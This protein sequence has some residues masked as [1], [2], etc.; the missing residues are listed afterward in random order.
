[1]ADAV[2]PIQARRWIVPAIRETRLESIELP[3]PGP[4]E[5]RVRTEASLVSAGTELAIYT[6]IH[7]G[8]TNPEARWPKLPVSMGYMGVVRVE[9]VGEK[10]TGLEP[11]HRLLT[12]T[13]HGSHWLLAVPPSG[14][15]PFWP[16]PSDL[17]ASRLVLARMGKTAITSVCQAGSTVAQSV[18]VVGLGIVG[19]MAL[20]LF[21]AAGAHPAIGVDP[22]GFRRGLALSGGA[23]ASVD[24][25]EED[26]PLSVRTL[27]RG[28]ADIVVDATGHAGA[29]PGAMALARDGGTV[30][31]LGSPRGAAPDVDFYSHLHRRSL[32]VVGAHDSGVGREVRENFPWTN[33]RVVPAIVEWIRRERLRVDDLVTHRVSPEKLPEMYELLLQH[34]DKVLGVVL[35]WEA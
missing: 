16:L 14:P 4:E 30:I 9:S 12:S 19:Q 18:A 2:S 15:W 26:A 33:E 29:L 8:L 28:G 3:P 11:G 17:P 20:R 21:L 25:T 1:M 24:P 27:T 7:Q 10:V 35:E 23:A 13:G 32:R 22:V 5:I 31:V 34:P 6:G